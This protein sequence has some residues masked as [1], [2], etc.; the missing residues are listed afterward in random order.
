MLI[1]I[2]TKCSKELPA[3]NNY[4]SKSATGKYNL[5][6]I[7]KLC[8]AEH[9]RNYYEQ[10][11]SKS[12]HRQKEY[13]NKNIEKESKRKKKYYEENKEKELNRRKK[14][15]M[16]NAEICRQSCRKRRCL[17]KSTPVTL[18]IDQ[19]DKIKNIFK[20]RCA[21]CG[22]ILPLEQEH[23]IP[24][25]NGGGYTYANIIPACKSCNA[26]K[27]NRDFFE[28]YPKHKSYSKERE[29]FILEHLSKVGGAK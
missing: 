12:L 24:L 25:S 11:K 10:N 7:C 5:R 22:R 8:D 4:F 1:K 6:S 9:S 2:C 15:R 27:N 21:Y 29:S 18:K 17:K 19:W 23:F 20:H 16:E 3:N 13:Y 26:S 14:Y 28:W